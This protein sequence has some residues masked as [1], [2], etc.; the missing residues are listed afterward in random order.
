MATTIWCGG[1]VFKP[2]SREEI[3]GLDNG[4]DWAEFTALPQSV[5]VFCDVCACDDLR[6]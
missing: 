2:W 3:I 5:D 6:M 1:L 4:Q